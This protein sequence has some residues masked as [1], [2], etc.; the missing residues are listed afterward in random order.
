[1][2]ACDAGTIGLLK[3][4]V[5]PWLRQA[6][7]AL[8]ALTIATAI[9]IPCVRFLFRPN[10]DEHF[11]PTGVPPQADALAARHLRLWTDPAARDR[12]IRQMR[13][14]NAE[15]DFMGR[16][17]FVLALANL[18]LREPSR[19]AEYLPVIDT[20]LDE[21]LRLERERGMYFFLMSYA[22]SADY[23]V[24]PVRSLF[25]D[26][27]IALMLAARRLIAEKP[28]YQPLLAGRVEAMIHAM[29]QSPVLLAE[30]YPDECWM[31]DHVMA[32]DA[33]R[34]ADALD[35]TGHDEFIRQ[36]I[37]TAKRKL[38]DEKT[39]LLCANFYLE[40][41]AGDGPEGSTLWHVAHGLQL[42]D[43]AFAADQYARAKRHLARR[44]CGFAYS[45]EWPASWEERRADVD[46]GPIIPGLQISAGASGLAFVGASAFG[47]REFQKQLLATLYMSAFPVRR[48]GELRFCASNQVGDAVLLYAMTLGPLWREI[49]R[50]TSP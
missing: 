50:R 1:M 35:G 8:A 31:F 38:V 22:R 27:E 14:S 3:T 15:W 40:G 44:V 42:L 7:I 26:G 4:Q 30:S 41:N 17:Y 16:T 6:G 37:E 21:T 33:I 32:L 5:K 45:R 12:E 36:W 28:E 2:P 46:S 19:Q 48:R 11:R 39:G 49:E 13:G 43:P 9:W 34:A 24:K 23:R 25:V 10:V 29:R 47:D 18:C 20:I